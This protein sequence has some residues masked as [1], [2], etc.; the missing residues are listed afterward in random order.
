MAPGGHPCTPGPVVKVGPGP[1]GLLSLEE[2]IRTRAHAEGLPC[3]DAERQPST[4]PGEASEEPPPDRDLGLQLPELGEMIFCCLNHPVLGILFQR[5]DPEQG[6]PGD[7]G[8]T[9]RERR[10]PWELE[11]CPEENARRGL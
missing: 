6:R 2:E 1:T 5:M 4:C 9:A 10:A 11:M 7:L 8:F 3:E